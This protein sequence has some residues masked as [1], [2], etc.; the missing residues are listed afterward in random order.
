MAGPSQLQ[1]KDLAISILCPGLPTAVYVLMYPPRIIRWL[2]YRL[3]YV[4]RGRV[5]LTFQSCFLSCRLSLQFGY[6]S[7]IFCISGVIYFEL[8]IKYIFLQLL[9]DRR[10]KL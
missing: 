3:V 1:S 2:L 10:L 7:H 4:Y 8:V 5:A 6:L 9:K